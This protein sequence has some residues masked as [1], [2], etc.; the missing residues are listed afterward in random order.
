MK[1]RAFER[2]FRA[3]ML[4]FKAVEMKFWGKMGE[5]LAENLNFSRQILC[6]LNFS[7][8]F[9]AAFFNAA[10]M[11]IFTA[12]TPIF[13]AARMPIFMAQMPIFKAAQNSTT[14]LNLPLNLA[15]N[16]NFSRQNPC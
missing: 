16:L 14:R 5:N 12:Q 6:L 11:P 15:E 8:A 1:F 3:K 7:V 10:R 9:F 13:K 2:K 4:K